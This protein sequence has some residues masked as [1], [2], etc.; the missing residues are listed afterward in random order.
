[1]LYGRGGFSLNRGLGMGTVAAANQNAC[2]KGLGET[3]EKEGG[4]KREFEG[5]NFSAGSFS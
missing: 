5:S 1:M 3:E 2:H 4:G